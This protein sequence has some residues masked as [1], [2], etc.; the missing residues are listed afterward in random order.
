M[1]LY[2]IRHGDAGDTM[3]WKADDAERPLT[4][5]GAERF[6]DL[7]RS[8]VAGGLK[9]DAV[10][11]SPLLRARQTA[12]L[13]AAAAGVA[14]VEEDLRVGPGFDAEALRAILG[15]H[16]KVDR[17]AF[18]GHEPDM[19]ALVSTLIGGGRI[20]FKKGAV[21]RIDAEDARVL[22]GMLVYLAVP[23]K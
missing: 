14:V 19:S 16:A 18:V 7:A 8:L 3:S 12:E 5:K 15:E 1:R 6:A 17:I 10:V 2:L 21:A 4:E 13:L 22:D 9:V 20:A 23:G 11:T